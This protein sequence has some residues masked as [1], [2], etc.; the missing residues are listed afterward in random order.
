MG[1]DED[2]DFGP[3]PVAEENFTSSSA[4]APE[5]ATFS[6]SSMSMQALIATIATCLVV[7]PA[8]QSGSTEP[9]RRKD[10]F[11]FLNNE[12][13]SAPQYL[14]LS[15]ALF[16]AVRLNR[17][18]ISSIDLLG[19]IEAF[20]D[21]FTSYA[22]SRDESMAIAGLDVLDA[23]KHVWLGDVDVTFVQAVNEFLGD[24]LKQIYTG[25]LRSCRVRTRLIRFCAS[26]FSAD[27]KERFWKAQVRIASPLPR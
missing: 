21:F 22:W 27:P 7:V 10:L 1:V 16:R 6:S 17:L 23:T 4:V 8:L 13:N 18:H 14:A 5:L 19:T 15:S 25:K 20:G 11:E 2:D 12:V 3:T 26:Y 9:T 24:F